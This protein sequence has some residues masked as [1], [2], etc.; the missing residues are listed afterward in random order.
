MRRSPI[1]S[2]EKQLT[3][4]VGKVLEEWVNLERLFGGE[5]QMT[6]SVGLLARFRHEGGGAS[7]TEYALWLATLAIGLA[8]GSFLLL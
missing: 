2:L 5:D 1:R 3:S 7:A 4:E 8:V 6:K